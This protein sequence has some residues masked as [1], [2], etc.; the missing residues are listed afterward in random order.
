VAQ[1]SLECIMYWPFGGPEYVQCKANAGRMAGRVTKTLSK[2]K[3]YLEAGGGDTDL[4]IVAHGKDRHS[5]GRDAKIYSD[6]KLF[7]RS[8]KNSNDIAADLAKLGTEFTAASI[9]GIYLWV[10]YSSG[11]GL[12][13]AVKNSLRASA[14][15]VWATPVLIGGVGLWNSRR[16]VEVQAN[17]F[18]LL[19]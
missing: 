16:G 3:T 12:G 4:V 5:P 6:D 19:P 18:V 9:Q 15:P 8:K 7:G 14:I 1:P 13:T 10:C 2:V 11:S 17:S